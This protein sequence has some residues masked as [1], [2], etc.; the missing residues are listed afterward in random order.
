MRRSASAAA[1]VAVV[2]TGA[3]AA[4]AGGGP[5]AVYSDFAQDGRLSC[6]HS[7]ADLNAALRSGT[8]NQYGDPYTLAGMKLAI[9]RQL[10]GSCQRGQSGGT[11]SGTPGSPN[12]G[13]TAPGRGK[14]K[15]KGR[16]RRPVGQPRVTPPSGH[17]TQ[18]SVGGSSGSFI[19]GRGL[20]LLGLVAALGLGGWLTKHALRARD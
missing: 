7:R 8:I 15:D 18:A 11:A 17:S 3:G 20:V 16:D 4:Y 14:G 19:A 13:G 6:D 1:I 10:A 5:S 2:A 9:R 12:Q